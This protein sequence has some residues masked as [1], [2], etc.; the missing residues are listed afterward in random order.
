MKN[1]KDPEVLLCLFVCL[2]WYLFILIR[3]TVIYIHTLNSF[4]SPSR[5]SFCL[6]FI[7][8]ISHHHYFFKYAFTDL[9]N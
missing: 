2:L 5:L 7:L 9:P 6:L 8:K 1:E 3:I 4:Y